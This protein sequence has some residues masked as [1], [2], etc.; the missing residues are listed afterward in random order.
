MDWKDGQLQTAEVK[1]IN[2][3]ACQVRSGGKTASLSLKP[4]TSIRLDSNLAQLK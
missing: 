3:T 4:G 2:G 1:S